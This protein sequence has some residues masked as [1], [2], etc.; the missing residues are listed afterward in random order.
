[1][2][3]G[4]EMCVTVCGVWRPPQFVVGEK[5][6]KT[7]NPCK[8]VVGSVMG[9]SGK[10]HGRPEMSAGRGWRELWWIL[11]NLSLTLLWI[12]TPSR[13]CSTPYAPFTVPAT[14]SHGRKSRKDWGAYDWFPS[15]KLPTSFH[16]N[17]FGGP[18]REFWGTLLWGIHN[19]KCDDCHEM[20][21][22]TA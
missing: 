16:R 6:W 8:Y 14:K 2:N 1:M 5:S 10:S 17:K 22:R 11:P 21:E 12:T 13:Y 19:S 18:I 3:C 4:W 20:A 7:G 9:V 15:M